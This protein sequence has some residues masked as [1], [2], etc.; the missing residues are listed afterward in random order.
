[1]EFK[2]LILPNPS[3]EPEIYRLVYITN[4]LALFFAGLVIGLL[5]ILIYLFS[6]SVSSPI[7]ITVFLIY[8][9]VP[10]LNKLNNLVG[11]MIFSLTPVI[12]TMIVTLYVKQFQREQSFVDFFDSRFILLSTLVVPGIIFRLREKVAFWITIIIPIILLML[13]DPIHEFFGVG[14]FQKGNL[15]PSYYY[16]NYIVFISVAVTVISTY[17]LRFVMERSESEILLKNVRLE[18]SR[19]EIT[20]QNRELEIKQ[21]EILGTNEKLAEANRI[22][23]EQQKSLE[24]YNRELETI[25]QEKNSELIRTNEELVKHNNDLVQF[26]YTVSHNLRGPVARLL[27]LSKLASTSDEQEFKMYL[28]LINKSG[29]ELDGVLKD[30]SMI[31]D[32]RNELNRVREKIKLQET[33][34]KA[35]E[36]VG[37]QIQPDF[38]FIGEFDSVPFIYGI[39]PMLDSMFYNMVSNAIK[40]R[41]PDKPLKLVVTSQIE[42]ERFTVLKFSDNGLGIDLTNQRNNIFKLYKRFHPAIGGKGMGLYLVKVQVEALGGQISVESEPGQGTTFTIR[43][44][45]PEEVTQQLFY[46]SGASQLV[47]DANLNVTLVIW[48]RN[49]L[50]NEYRETFEKILATLK[51]YNSRGWI[52]DLRNQGVIAPEDQEWFTKTILPQALASGLRLVC[53][54]GFS[55]PIRKDYL[56]RMKNFSKS[57]GIVFQDFQTIPEAKAWIGANSFE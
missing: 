47:F 27:G 37:E 42:E 16:I 33:L 22:I 45:I 17:I 39:R 2:R 28:E 6:W 34:Q 46:E 18:E 41:K 4:V 9:S 32:I 15:V 11:R 23:S 43:L 1:M 20:K 3:L 29:L 51:T 13:F 54:I 50:S 31:I 40:Y 25:V 24:I 12:F 35:V 8:L 56:E 14:F 55:D 53:S 19:A 26:S 49:I 44:P 38:S 48:K 5:C 30:L 57:H 36:M 21:I 10:Y 52:A 7:L